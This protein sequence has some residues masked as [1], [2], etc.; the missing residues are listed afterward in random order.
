MRYGQIVQMR[1]KNSDL[2]SVVVPCF[3]SG[4]TLKR[5]LNS[6]I[7][8]TWDQKEIM[9]FIDKENRLLRPNNLF[10][11]SPGRGFEIFKTMTYL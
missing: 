4:K 9:S 1:N 3:N 11:P 2:I 6:I 10:E 8:Q 7:D 5:T